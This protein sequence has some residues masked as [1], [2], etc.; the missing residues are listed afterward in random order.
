[1]RQTR[2]VKTLAVTGIGAEPAQTK[3]MRCLGASIVGN[4]DDP[5]KGREKM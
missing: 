4:Y 2:G 5:A 3:G 1:M